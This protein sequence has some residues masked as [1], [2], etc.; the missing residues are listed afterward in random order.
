M[1]PDIHREAALVVS[2]CEAS[3]YYTKEDQSDPFTF[4]S[5]KPE[6]K[7]GIIQFSM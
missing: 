6:D 3:Q 2:H 5:I 7:V 1:E 4:I